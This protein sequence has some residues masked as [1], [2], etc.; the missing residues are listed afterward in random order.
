MDEIKLEYEDYLTMKNVAE[1]KIR[2]H[3][4]EVKVNRIVYDLCIK[5]LKNAKTKKRLPKK[6][7]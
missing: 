4:L 7:S 2:F 5:E 3:L 6:T 1:E